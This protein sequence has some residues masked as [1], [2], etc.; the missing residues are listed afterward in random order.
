MIISVGGQGQGE[1]CAELTFNVENC[2]FNMGVEDPEDMFYKAIQEARQ[3]SP[4]LFDDFT[5]VALYA[6]VMHSRPL[7]TGQGWRL[8]GE[9]RSSWDELCELADTD[10]AQML[11][12]KKWAPSHKFTREIHSWFSVLQSQIIDVDNTRKTFW[13]YQN[14]K[15][16]KLSDGS[17]GRY[18]ELVWLWEEDD[19]HGKREY[20]KWTPI[21]PFFSNNDERKWRLIEGTRIERDTQY[22]AMTSVFSTERRHHFWIER[23]SGAR[24][25]FVHVKVQG[26]IDE[27][28]ALSVPEIS[29]PM[30]ATFAFIDTNSIQEIKPT[31]LNLTGVVVHRKT[32]SDF[33]LYSNFLEFNPDGFSIVVVIK[34]NLEAINRQITALTDA[35]T[36]RVYGDVEGQAGQGYSLRKTILAQGGEL[37]RLYALQD[38]NCLGKPNCTRVLP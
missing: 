19:K 6:V 24:D 20:H 25:C 23:E 4:R 32:S 17:E 29:P 1:P 10:G 16:L 5:T 18:P 38:K 26:Q 34:P 13:A 12:C 7:R 21:N 9:E 14:K 11:V 30:D 3:I 22:R 35:G 28:E 37:N 33:V 27:E 8:Q 36:T 15:P 2:T 31:D